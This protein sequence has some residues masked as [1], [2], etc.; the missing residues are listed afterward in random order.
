MYN[1]SIPRLWSRHAVVAIA[2]QLRG[3]SSAATDVTK[4]V[5]DV[6][7]DRGNYTRV[8]D[9]DVRHFGSLLGE[10]NVLTRNLGPY[11]VDYLKHVTGKFCLRK[12]DFHSEK[13]M[14]CSIK[15]LVVTKPRLWRKEKFHFLRFWF[16]N[17]IQIKKFS[18]VNTNLGQVKHLDLN[19]EK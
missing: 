12:Y 18:F 15:T 9:A 6:R 13:K 14:K 7:H 16:N 10:A 5:N 19:D 2:R 4:V 17:I 11:N 1:S 3:R 8:T